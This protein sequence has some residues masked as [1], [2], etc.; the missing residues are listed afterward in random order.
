MRW[1]LLRQC[2]VNVGSVHGV[3]HCCHACTQ[4]PP[5]EVTT[6][7]PWVS[8]TQSY[9]VTIIMLQ[10]SWGMSAVNGGD[11]G[12]ASIRFHMWI[13]LEIKGFEVMEPLCRIE[14]AGYILK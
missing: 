7:R 4:Q 12:H 11:D 6:V 2:T 3:S 9:A 10:K 1:S 5:V 8:D 14:Y 13:A